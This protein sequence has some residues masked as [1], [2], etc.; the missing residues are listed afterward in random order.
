MFI[1]I[2]FTF[3]C[4]AEICAQTKVKTYKHI[5]MTKNK[6]ETKIFVTLS[7]MSSAYL[8]L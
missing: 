7:E 3:F 8:S 2:P 6:Y 4:I 5:I 1:L